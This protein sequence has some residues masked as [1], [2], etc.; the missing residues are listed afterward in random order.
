MSTPA[1]WESL[2]PGEYLGWRLL[3]LG[4]STVFTVPGDFNCTLLR[5]CMQL[6]ISMSVR[7]PQHPHKQLVRQALPPAWH[8]SSLYGVRCCMQSGCS[9]LH[10]LQVRQRP[11]NYAYQAVDNMYAVQCL[12]WMLWHLFLASEWSTATAKWPVHTQQVRTVDKVPK[13]RVYASSTVQFSCR[14]GAA[15]CSNS[16]DWQ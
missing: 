15:G 12:S 4:C 7:V 2:S 8:N 11:C 10:Y 3:Q 1:D 5:F 16:K 14:H 13:Q 9:M 6:M